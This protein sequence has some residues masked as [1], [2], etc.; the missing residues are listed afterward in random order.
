[1][2][3]R[4]RHLLPCPW[5]LKRS[6]PSTHLEAVARTVARLSQPEGDALDGALYLAGLRLPAPLDRG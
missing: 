6:R 5:V 4:P 3:I 1:M 2:K